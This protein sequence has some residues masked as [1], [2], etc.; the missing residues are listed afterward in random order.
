[1]LTAASAEALANASTHHPPNVTIKAAFCDGG[2]MVQ[3][4][5]GPPTPLLP[6]G[7]SMAQVMEYVAPGP[8][9]GNK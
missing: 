6:L 9:K 3:E 7:G 2:S 5:G 1:M 8:K 4:V